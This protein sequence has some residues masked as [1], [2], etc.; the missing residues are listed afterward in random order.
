MRKLLL[1]A[2]MA[3]MVCLTAAQTGCKSNKETETTTKSTTATQT[4]P[5]T[6]QPETEE[7][8][9]EVKPTVDLDFKP[10]DLYQENMEVF[11]CNKDKSWIDVDEVVKAMETQS[12]KLDSET[13]YDYPLINSQYVQ[14]VYSNPAYEC[15]VK[16]GN[17]G[18]RVSVMAN[19]KTKTY[20]DDHKVKNII[21]NAMDLKSYEEII[22]TPKKA[23]A[24]IEDCVNNYTMKIN[25]IPYT[26]K[27]YDTPE[28]VYPGFS[29]EAIYYGDLIENFAV[30][31]KYK[32]TKKLE[33]DIDMYTSGKV[34]R[35]S[36]ESYLKEQKMDGDFDAEKP[37]LVYATEKH[38]DKL[39]MVPMLELTLDGDGIDDEMEVMYSL[40][41]S[42]VYKVIPFSLI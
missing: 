27:C 26:T 23:G 35:N 15:T 5:T 39:Y 38:N 25:D 19:P 14:Q 34:I 13:T 16:S 10:K 22:E 36:L 21:E 7:E 17:W 30:G 41:T 2:T 1:V 8:T 29:I 32:T 28:A 33:G 4:E 20:V 37:N 3:A 9:K 18:I 24:K 12:L 42:N 11:L 31:V 40:Y 6:T